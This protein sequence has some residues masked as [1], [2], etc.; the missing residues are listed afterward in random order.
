MDRRRPRRAWTSLRRLFCLRCGR[1]LFAICQRSEKSGR[2]VVMFRLVFCAAFLCHL[3]DSIDTTRQERNIEC[4]DRRDAMS[5]IVGPCR[6]FLFA[7]FFRVQRRSYTV[8]FIA[9]SFRPFRKQ[10]ASPAQVFQAVTPPPP[11]LSLPA[12]SFLAGPFFSVRQS[13]RINIRYAVSISV[14]KVRDYHRNQRLAHLYVL[15]ELLRIDQGADN[16]YS[17]VGT[18]HG[19]YREWNYTTLRACR[20]CFLCASSSS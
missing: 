15:H 17:T 13:P 9:T 4:G 12:T 1:N 16:R 5:S 18:Y 14:Q 2:L 3:L 10:T 20:L 7:V 11:P 19:T 6:S 8:L